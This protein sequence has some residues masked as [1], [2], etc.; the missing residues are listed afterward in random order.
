MDGFSELVFTEVLNY[1]MTGSCSVEPMTV[2]GLACAAEKF[3]VE[4]LKQAC[5]ERLSECLSV[6]S[7]CIVLSHLEKYLS[8]ASSKAMIVQ[9]LQFVDSHASEILVSDG[10]LDLS[11]NMVHLVL[12]R[13]SSQTDVPEILKV[14]AIFAWGER[15]SKPGGMSMYAHRLTLTLYTLFKMPTC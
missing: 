7:I 12:R 9:C 4:E 8:Y 5:F 14:R 6:K 1:L 13:D 2:V 15:K 3:E 11:E 10:F